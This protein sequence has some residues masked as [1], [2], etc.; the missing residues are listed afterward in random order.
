[1]Q[2]VWRKDTIGWLRHWSI[3]RK[4]ILSPDGWDRTHIRESF[5]ESI[6]LDEFDERMRRSSLKNSPAVQRFLNRN[7]E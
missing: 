4:D 2:E 7:D 3:E 5:N 6:S 1:M